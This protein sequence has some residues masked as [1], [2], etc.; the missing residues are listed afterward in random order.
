MMGS[1]PTINVREAGEVC[2]SPASLGLAPNSVHHFT[3][4]NFRSISL[5]ATPMKTLLT[6]LC[7][8]A[9][10]LMNLLGAE[11]ATP[12]PT[13]VTTSSGFKVVA[14]QFADIQ[15]LRYQVPEFDQL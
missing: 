5:R 14:D 11:P 3:A 6:F 1:L 2:P 9:F 8:N 7:G 12:G 10:C 13:S 15:V 4:C